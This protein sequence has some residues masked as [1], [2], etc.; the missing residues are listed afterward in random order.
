VSNE[1]IQQLLGALRAEATTTAMDSETRSAL[2][3]LDSDIHRLLDSPSE[4]GA[5]GIVQRAQLLEAR[6]AVDHPTAERFMRDVIDLL[7]KIGL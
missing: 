1:K 2:R 7:V 4:P 5:S 3:Q 6:F